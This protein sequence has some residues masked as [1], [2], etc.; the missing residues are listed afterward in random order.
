MNRL[1]KIGSIKP[2]NSKDIKYSKIGLGFEKLDRGAFDPEKAYD[3][4]AECGVKKARI[5]SGWAK[6]EKEKGVYDYAWL[7]TVVDNLLKRGI[8]PWLNLCY[9]NA[10]YTEEAKTVFGAVGCPPIKTKE[11]R[12]AWARY[13]KETVKRYKGK[14]TYYEIWNEPDGQWCWKHGINGTELGEFTKATAIAI[15]EADPEAKTIGGAWFS[16]KFWFFNEAFSTGMG[17]Y[18]DYISY[19]EYTCDERNVYE[20]VETLKALAH[21]YNPNIEII[22]GES[23]SQS[24]SGGHGAISEGFWTE[25]IQAKQLARHTMADYISDVHFTSY[26]SCMDMME[27]LHGDINDK[28][29][30][31]DFGYFGILGADFDEDGVATGVYYK[32]PSYYVLQNICSVFAEENE[33]C[34]IPLFVQNEYSWGKYQN[35]PARYEI[36][37]GGFKNDSGKAFVY[38]Y[39]ANI[40]TTS[41]EGTITVEFYTEYD[42]FNLVD[43]MDGS[44]YEIPETMI[45][46]KG[47]GAYLIKDL[48]IKDTPL[49]LTFGDFV[50]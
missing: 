18:L 24:R 4:V 8:E 34:S 14:I 5:Q 25:A 29:S 2:K 30:Y 15:K 6:T 46:N 48:P 44:I 37:S 45:E 42:K 32:K 41:Y 43:I 16:R 21:R 26:F 49:L 20:K 50:K 38:W 23:G 39:P 31:M 9:G 7:D 35:Q 1:I 33:V 19:H 22:Q 17:E 12:D 36:T 13:V 10:L 28:S 27:A 11:E 40:M 3:K 47:N